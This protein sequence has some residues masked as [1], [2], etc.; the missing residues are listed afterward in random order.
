V[1]VIDVSVLAQ[2]ILR[3]EGWET[4][5]SFIMGRCRAPQ[6]MV[7][8]EVYNTIWKHVAL[9]H[10][11]SADAADA[12]IQS[13]TIITDD[14]L[15]IEPFRPLLMDAFL[16]VSASQIPVYDAIYLAHAQ[17]HGPLIT[18]DAQQ[19]RVAEERGIPLQF[20]K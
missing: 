8:A 18:S 15:T 1:T 4:T 7:I 9:Y 13:L 19:A 16:V 6:T 20:L 2:Y 12:M 11:V 17:H 3:E 10:R 5:E 14:L